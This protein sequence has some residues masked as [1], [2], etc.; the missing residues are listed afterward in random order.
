MKIE[1]SEFFD[2][3]ANSDEEHDWIIAFIGRH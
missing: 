2:A 3:E 1:I